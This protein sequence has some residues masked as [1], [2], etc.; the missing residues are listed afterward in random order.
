MFCEESFHVMVL[1]FFNIL[2]DTVGEVTW[3]GVVAEVGGRQVVVGNSR[4][5]R[6]EGVRLDP[7]Q[8]HSE[9]TWQAKGALVYMQSL[10]NRKL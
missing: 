4:L 8:A 7:P 1:L 10:S 9:A 2:A 5:L 6:G 3:Q